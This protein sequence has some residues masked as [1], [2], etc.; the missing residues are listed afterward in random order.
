MKVDS[1]P[2]WVVGVQGTI[3]ILLSGMV[4]MLPWPLLRLLIVR[5]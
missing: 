3:E 5:A 1:A 4:A 2:K